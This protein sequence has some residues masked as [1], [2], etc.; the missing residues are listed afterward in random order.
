MEFDTDKLLRERDG[1]PVVEP[2]PDANGHPQPIK[3][4]VKDGI[5][6]ISKPI[7]FKTRPVTYG[8][9]ACRAIDQRREGDD[10]LQPDD[11]RKR[12]RTAR[13]MIGGGKVRL[14]PDEVMLIATRI[15]SFGQVVAGQILDELYGDASSYEESA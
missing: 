12:D 13:K 6:D 14:A 7:A 9:V 5:L 8:M 15:V 2:A 11:I 10:K 3:W 1:R 4:E